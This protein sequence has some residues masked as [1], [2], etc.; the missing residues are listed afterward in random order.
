MITTLL[1]LRSQLQDR[2]CRLVIFLPTYCYNPLEAN[3]STYMV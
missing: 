2:A 1:Q 3:R